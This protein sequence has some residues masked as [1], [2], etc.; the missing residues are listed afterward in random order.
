MKERTLWLVTLWLI[1]TTTLNAQDF[2]N[3]QPLQSQGWVPPSF[4]TSSSQKYE[5]DKASTT[6]RQKTER[7]FY[8]ENNFVLDQLLKSGQIIFNDSADYSSFE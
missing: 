4:I 2:D 7:K 8:L 1:A 3:Y 5:K 6:N